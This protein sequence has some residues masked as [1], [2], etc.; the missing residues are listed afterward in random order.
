MVEYIIEIKESTGDWRYY[1][2]GDIHEANP[3]KAS[4]FLGYYAAA[5]HVHR[6]LADAVLHEPVEIRIVPAHDDT[7]W[8]FEE[9]MAR[10]G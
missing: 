3:D 5:K 9:I 1:R 2:D 6:V 4:R 7:T 8:T 10:E